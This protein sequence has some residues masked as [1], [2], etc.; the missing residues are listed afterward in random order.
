[1]HPN[2]KNMH[3]PR[4]AH[5]HYEQDG[6]HSESPPS[7]AA[8]LESITLGSDE[9]NRQLLDQIDQLRE[10]RV[11]QYIDLPQ[12]VVVGDQSTGK[13]SVLEALTNIP[14]PRSSVKCTKFATQIRLRRADEIET[15]IGILPGEGCSQKEKDRLSGFS[16]TI[17]DHADFDTIFN[18][19][20]DAIFPPGI[21]HSF[22][23][24]N[25]LSIEIS[26]PSQP[27]LTV[28]DLPGIIH[29]PTMDQ[30][31]DDV[32]AI[33][34]LANSYMQKERTIILIVVSGSNDISNQVVLKKAKELDTEGNRTLG[35]ITKPDMAQ[36][37]KQR[38]EFIKL[39]SN[40]DSKNKLQ[41]RWH[42]LRN[43][44]HNEMHFSMEE[45]NEAERNFFADSMWG[46]RLDANQL[47]AA[48]LSKKLSTQLIR[49]I[50]TEA[51]K[52][53]ADIERELEKCRSKLAK[54]GEGHDTIDEMSTELFRLCDRS[55]AITHAAVLG[56]G[57]HPSGD[58]N[59]FPSYDDGKNYARNFRS[60][61]VRQN[62]YFAEHMESW[63]ADCIIVDDEGG[64]K[65]KSQTHLGEGIT[66]PEIPRSE[67]INKVVYPLLRDNHGLE[68]SMDSNPLLVFRLFQS[69]SRHWPHHA[70][71]HIKSIHKLCEDFL[72]HVLAFVW[73]KQIRNRVWVC[74]VKSK[75]DSMLV[76]AQKELAKLT[77]D[78]LKLVTPY[79]SE[80]LN[81]YY[82][83]KE[84][85]PP[86]QSAAELPGQRYEDVLRKMLLLYQVRTPHTNFPEI[87]CLTANFH[88]PISKHLS[89]T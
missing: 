10:C 88:S 80:F 63:G 23:S 15:K 73:P 68:L 28:V 19:A 18:L 7:Y 59:F 52:V 47:G 13:S 66:I 17:Q 49:H 44:A 79:E 51:F 58:E 45:R 81:R 50:A 64:Q 20:K 55:R 8:T 39:A 25:I 70:S 31:E 72:D 42:V 77:T 48:H 65:V 75:V 22:L 37:D 71:E 76:E 12:I 78:R 61:V 40:E 56:H 84:S 34:S 9:E 21:P 46:A 26:G 74:F 54:M 86:P 38:L 14:F 27:H 41:L 83:W 33:N 1:M 35:I 32:E 36:T 89:Q 4:Y 30:T 5:N 60:R 16:Q 67:Y 2:M 69:Y 3:D 29:T 53:Q 82:A 11:D 24:Q 85:D 6:H 57:I 62:A 43:R 87:A